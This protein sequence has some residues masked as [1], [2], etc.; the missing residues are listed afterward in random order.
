MGETAGDYGPGVSRR[1]NFAW[2]V[3]SRYGFSGEVICAGPAM[4][5]TLPRYVLGGWHLCGRLEESQNKL[6][7]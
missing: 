3:D 2:L 5:A 6:R 7:V 4:E 1:E